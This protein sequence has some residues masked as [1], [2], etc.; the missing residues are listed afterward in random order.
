LACLTLQQHL[1]WRRGR[2][3]AGKCTGKRQREQTRYGS[4][5]V[6][7]D[8]SHGADQQSVGTGSLS[9]CQSIM[10]Q[11]RES[12]GAVSSGEIR[13]SA[14]RARLTVLIELLRTTG[15]SARGA[16]QFDGKYGSI[17]HA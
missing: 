5:T 9:N 2:S 1:G 8:C 14:T 4:A 6:G 17:G 13:L 16:P 15:F 12:M 11:R 3:L 7:P 10:R